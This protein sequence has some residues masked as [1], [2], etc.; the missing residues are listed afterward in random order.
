M[1]IFVIILIGI[2]CA[3]MKLCG[4]NEFY[5][6]YLCQ[7]NTTT[8]N[9][10]FSV[11]IFLSHAAQYVSLNGSL[12]QPYLEMRTWLGQLVV[13]TYL[14]FSG[15]GIMESIKKK[16]RSYVKGMPVNRLLKLWYQF[17]LM[18]VLFI[19]VAFII[20]R[21]MNLPDTL[22]AFTGYTSLGNSNWYLL[23]TFLMY[24]FIYLAF[25]VSGKH[26]WL[27][28]TLT[29]LLTLGYVA[30]MIK[31]EHLPLRFYDTVLCFPLGMVYSAAKPYLDR[32]LMKN[33][34]VWTASLA[35]I[36][37]VFMYFSQNRA[38]SVYH[39]MAFLATAP[40][41]IAVLMMKLN[42]SSSILDWFGRHIFS[43]FMLQRIPMLLLKHFGFAKE[44]YFFMV[45][46]FVGTVLLATAF[47][48]MIEKLDPILFRKKKKAVTS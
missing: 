28:L 30:L 4:K 45:L 3:G 29:C 23:V 1:L 12:D 26:R 46:C 44:P 24:I 11:L 15:F 20:G 27:G 47:D 32:L 9:A 8:V 17:A 37:T 6:D 42:I 34:V 13:V 36:F 35:A 16:G 31:T 25:M 19:I 21:K 7:K 10:I 38:D 5:E 18:L 39:R 22:L 48:A 33:D 40:L 43:F 14:F 2:L 41:L